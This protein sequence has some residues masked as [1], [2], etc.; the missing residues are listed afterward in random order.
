MVLYDYLAQR[1]DEIQLSAGQIVNVLDV[2]ERDWWKVSVLNQNSG[3]IQQGYFP[4]SYLGKLFANERPLQVIQTIQV[5]NGDICDKLLRGQ[6]SSL[7]TA[8][9][10]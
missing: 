10:K 7:T 3:L 1:N 4:S 6:V 8:I 5:S 9:A 2:Q